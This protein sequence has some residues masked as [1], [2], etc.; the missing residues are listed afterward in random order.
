MLTKQ[1]LILCAIRASQRTM[2]KISIYTDMP[3]STV[4][5]YLRSDPQ[6]LVEI[7]FVSYEPGRSATFQLTLAGQQ[8][9][10][11]ICLIREGRRVRPGKVELC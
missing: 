1:L 11:N 2:R 4:N 8:V 6:N 9:I 7:G 10:Q 3:L 5:N